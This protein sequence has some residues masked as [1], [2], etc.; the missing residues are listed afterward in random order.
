MN[1]IVHTFKHKQA[2]EKWRLRNTDLI[3]QQYNTVIHHA[4]YTM[5]VSRVYNWKER[6]GGF[7]RA[8]NWILCPERRISSIV[9]VHD[10]A[11]SLTRLIAENDVRSVAK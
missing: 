2:A 9:F 6:T 1:A 11:I 3:L 4:F 8:A 7:I 10:V 5:L